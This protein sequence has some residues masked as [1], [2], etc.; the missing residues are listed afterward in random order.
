MGIIRTSQQDIKGYYDA[1]GLNQSSL[2][3]LL[4]SRKDFLYP[5]LFER[6]KYFVIGSAVDHFLTAEENTFDNIFCILDTQKP[7]EK[8]V[9]ILETVLTKAIQKDYIENISLDNCTDEITDAIVQFNWQPNWKMETRI[10]KI[11]EKGRDYFQFLKES[12]GKE[13]ITA[14]E[15]D[16]ALNVAE[17]FKSSNNTSFLFTDTPELDIYYQLPIYF[18]Y[19]DISCKALLDAVI[20]HHDKEKN[21]VNVFPY[22]I[23]TTSKNTID[24]PNDLKF[25]RY[26]IQAAFYMQALEYWVLDKYPSV[27][28]TINNFSF[29]VGSTVDEVNPLVF[30]CDDSILS[31]G[32]R[33][34]NS[35]ITYDNRQY[36]EKINGYDQII[37]DYLWYEENGWEQDRVIVENNGQ[38]TV[39]WSGIV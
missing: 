4:K 15:L 16:I 1:K 34:S 22:D 29:V 27:A 32:K 8:E 10:N 19:K 36:F 26:D 25:Y 28:C 3:L 21:I 35:L 20:V 12:E 39:N 23:K 31:I 37:D 7:S 33:G 38:F 5:P 18:K 2:K 17:A 9:E 11:L 30:K 14:E 6:K 24:F 13:I